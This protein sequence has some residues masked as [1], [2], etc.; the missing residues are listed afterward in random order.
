MAN[1]SHTQIVAEIR[2]FTEPIDGNWLRLD[3]L[4]TELWQFGRPTEAIPDLLGVFERMPTAYSGP[5]WGIVHGLEDLPEYAPHLAR[6]V[7][8]KPSEFAVMMLGRMLNGG[9]T[10]IDGE[11]I[12]PMLQVVADNP[13]LPAEVRVTATGFMERHPHL[14]QVEKTTKRK[15]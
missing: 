14:R 13:E 6:S 7:A 4:V 1:R 11:P 3:G 8:R 9:I 12:F 10:H 2:A 5:L 15:Q